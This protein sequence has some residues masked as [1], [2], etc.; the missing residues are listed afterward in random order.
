M[1]IEA[2]PEVGF[3]DGV[4]G[5]VGSFEIL[6]DDARVLV[7]VGGIAPDIKI[8]PA[9]SGRGVARALKPG[10]LVRGVIQHHLGDYANSAA[11]RLLQKGLKIAQPAGV[12]VDLLVVR[13]IVAII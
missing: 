1:R 3:R 10:M 8:A 4:P 6:E 9:A 2:M 13:D 7:F 5:P 11:M 12:S